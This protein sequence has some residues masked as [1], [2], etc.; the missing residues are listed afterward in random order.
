MAEYKVSINATPSKV[1]KVDVTPRVVQN[2][3]VA[4]PDS[5]L[6]YSNLSKQWAIG[7]GLIQSA[8]YSSKHYANISAENAQIAEAEANLC[9][10]KTEELTSNFESYNNDLLVIT[11]SSKEE[12]NSSAESAKQEI[13]TVS[14]SAKQEI[15]TT[16]DEV[17]QTITTTKNSAVT[18]IT[19]EGQKQLQNIESTGF[20][21]RDDK[22]YFINSNGEEEEFKS[23]GGAGLEIGDIGITPLGIDETKGKRRYLN[24]QVIIQD[25]YVEFTT[26]V[27]N[28]MALYPSIVCTEQEW[29][30]TATMT[31][32]GQV[33]KFVV[34]DDAGTIRLPKI[35]MP[36][37]GLTDLSKLAEI[38]EAGLP[39]IT[40]STGGNG[41]SPDAHGTGAFTTTTG[42][43]SFVGGAFTQKSLSFD[44]S[45]SNPIYGNSNTVQQEQIQYPYFIQ[46][47][48][49]AETEDN[50]TNTIELN[51]PYSFG[52]SKYSQ[53]I[54]NNLSWLRSAGQYNPK[55]T[56]PSY[57]DWLLTEY[58]NPTTPNVDVIGTPTFNNGVYSGFSTYNYVRIPSTF[59]DTSQPWEFV[60]PLKLSSFGTTN[61]Y[62]FCSE[63]YGFGL[64]VGADGTLQTYISSNGTSWN[65]NSGKVSS[66]TIALNT[67]YYIKTAW[68]GT[69]YV[70]SVSTDKQNYTP[71]ITIDNINPI[72]SSLFKF[73]TGRATAGQSLSHGEI[74]I[75]EATL[76]SNGNV[77]WKGLSS[78]VKMS[79]EAYTDYDWVINS[80]DE[81]FR[82]PLKTKLA[83][84][85]AV[86]GN[87]IALGLTDGT[88]NY[89]MYTSTYNGNHLTAVT[90][91]LGKDVG[92]TTGTGTTIADTVITGVT[93]DPNNSGIETSSQG[94]YL[95]FYVGETVQNANLINAGRIE[96][97]LVDV[98][99]K[100]I[101]SDRETVTS[102]FMPDLTGGINIT[103]YSSS[104]NQY[105]IP[106]NGWINAYIY[107]NSGASL[108]VNNTPIA[109][110]E[111]SGATIAITSFVPV[112]KGDTVYVASTVRTTYYYP[113]KGAK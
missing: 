93:T 90:N 10:A 82:L 91:A 71:Y 84:G 29:Q 62:I 39:N 101:L 61:Q 85:K 108:Y 25:Q 46:V 92:T 80:A 70:V 97:K 110:V 7:D 33:G 18:K 56:Y 83:S 57:Y 88:N 44:A 36:I 107:T 1:V 79:T 8:D 34:D 109:N 100:D 94:L 35:I 72:A 68:T 58:N 105:I 102:W 38:V 16:K 40:G 31:V 60:I 21:M 41:L 23:G 55:A 50:I 6:Y 77:W 98:V 65:I 12:I 75:F 95:Y 22:L 73:G 17:I 99:H 3:I 42:S 106:V 13:N 81:T 63:S 59:V 54:L 74:N 103:S 51:N 43:L 9:T 52:D 113:M 14:T 112:S 87:G 78:K 89:G 66:L 76:T 15:T 30:A 37:Q 20:Y 49:G 69:Q 111:T 5:S 45:H 28:A 86:V 67:Q 24:G 53:I 4:T 48:T 104:T 32:G 47:A 26:K 2:D 11:N 96:E 64:N 19:Q 27:K